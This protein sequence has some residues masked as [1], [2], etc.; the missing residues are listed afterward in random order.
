MRGMR[1]WESKLSGGQVLEKSEARPEVSFIL[2]LFI[3][4]YRFVC[5]Y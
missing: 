4:F 5:N 3:L 2:P 1:M